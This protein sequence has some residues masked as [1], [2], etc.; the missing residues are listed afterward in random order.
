MSKRIYV[1][2]LPFSAG[3][4]EVRATFGEFGKVLSVETSRGT[5]TVE[6][7]DDASADHA[8]SALHQREMDGKSLNVNEARPRES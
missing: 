3:D 2:N 6:M 8:I 7:A 5:A 1:E 4:D